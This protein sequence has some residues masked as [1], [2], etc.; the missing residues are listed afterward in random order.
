MRIPSH[1]NFLSLIVGLAL[2]TL[3]VPAAAGSF[4]Q[5]ETDDGG[6]AFTDDAKRVPARYRDDAVLIERDGFDDFDRYTETGPSHEASYAARTEARVQYLRDLNARVVTPDAVG[7]PNASYSRGLA[8]R[9]SRQGQD[10][11]AYVSPEGDAPVVVETVRSRPDGSP[12]TRHVTIVRQGDRVLS[13][14]AP[15]QRHSSTRSL[16]ERTLFE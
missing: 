10:V 16:D 3:A 15:Q 1:P 5:Y 13:V 12:V 14:I 9:S 2:A 6:I 7:A 4:Y 11:E 8:V